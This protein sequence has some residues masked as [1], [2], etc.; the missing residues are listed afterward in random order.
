[1]G[2]GYNYGISPSGTYK[3]IQGDTFQKTLVIRLT[4]GD[5]LDGTVVKAVYF[6]CDK[7]NI[8]DKLIEPKLDPE[9]KQENGK[10]K[11]IFSSK[12][13]EKFPKGST[14][15]DITILFGK[16]QDNDIVKTVRYQYPLEVLPKINNVIK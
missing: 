11:L 14:T 1:M 2:C 16:G 4:G 5:R 8:H 6:T 9:G 10:Y 7:L 3:I 12:D 13:T 15:Y